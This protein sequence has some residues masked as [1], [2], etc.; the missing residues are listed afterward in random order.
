MCPTGGH[1]VV[2]FICRRNSEAFT[3]RRPQLTHQGRE[4]GSTVPNGCRGNVSCLTLSA[5]IDGNLQHDSTLLVA[6]QSEGRSGSCNP[7]AAALKLRP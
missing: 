7:T 6:G 1:K 4:G 3:T 2:L 5:G